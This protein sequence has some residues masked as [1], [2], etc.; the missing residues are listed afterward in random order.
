MDCSQV[1]CQV[2]SDCQVLD[3]NSECSSFSSDCQCKDGFSVDYSL[4]K[5]TKDVSHHLN[6]AQN[7]KHKHA[8]QFI[9]RF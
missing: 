6:P 3:P 5:C 8:L 2:D 4:Q 7:Y 1:S 9:R